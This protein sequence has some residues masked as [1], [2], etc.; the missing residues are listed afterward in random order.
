MKLWQAHAVVEIGKAVGEVPLTLPAPWKLDQLGFVV[1]I[2]GDY[3]D[4]EDDLYMGAVAEPF[5][6]EEGVTFE[7]RVE[8]GPEKDTVMVSLT[9][10]RTRQPNI[11]LVKIVDVPMPKTDDL[12]VAITNLA[13]LGGEIAE[14][15]AD[16]VTEYMVGL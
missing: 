14:E 15:I 12:A 5:N 4:P 13:K 1:F 9:Q 7:V 10:G 11:L 3:E 8:A 2:D 16:K 6:G